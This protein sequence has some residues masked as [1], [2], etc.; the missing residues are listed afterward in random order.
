MKTI[1]LTKGKVA[2][3]SDVDYP[4][5]SQFNWYANKIKGI[6]YAFRGVRQPKIAKYLY[7]KIKIIAMHRDIMNPPAGL[8]IDHMDH[9][10]LNNQRGNLRIVTHSENLR[11][12]NPNKP[13]MRGKYKRSKLKVA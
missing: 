7:G 1:P 12:P 8:V 4:Y 10:G 13:D 11:N 9:N 3:V 5:L 2:L 6:W